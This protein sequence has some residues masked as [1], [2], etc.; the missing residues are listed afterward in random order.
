MHSIIYLDESGDLGWKF[1]RPYRNGGSS[2]FLTIGFFICPVTHKPIP[3]RIVRAVYSKFGFDPKIEIKASQLKK[4]HKEFIC[5]QIIATLQ[6]YPEMKS[7]A[8]TVKKENV[9]SHI[10]V[11]SNKLYNYMIR[12]SVLDKIDQ[13]ISSTL[14]RDNRSIKVASGNSLIDYLQTTLFFEHASST[15]L[16]DDP[17]HSH[18]ED[19]IMLAD[20]ISNIIW[21]K[22][23]DGLDG[24]FNLLNPH[25][26][27][28]EL[29]H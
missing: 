14:T 25:L 6:K 3:K 23:E 8:I 17:K 26:N 19:G 4:H 13:H 1:D 16:K 12:R 10:R 28:I 5:N 27:H 29:Y 11:D 21:E 15:S 18:L 20:W 24:G 7:G 22:H 9:H 2:R